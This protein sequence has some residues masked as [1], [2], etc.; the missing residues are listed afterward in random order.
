ML[1]TALSLTLAATAGFAT[2]AENAALAGYGAKITVTC[3]HSKPLNDRWAKAGDLLKAK[4]PA[5]PIIN[6]LKSARINLTFPMALSLKEVGVAMMGKKDGWSRAAA[7]DV[8]V[9]GTVIATITPDVEADGLQ[10]FPVPVTRTNALTL[11]VTKVGPDD[12]KQVYGGFSQVQ[13]I[14]EEDL[15]ALFAPPEMADRAPYVMPTANLGLRPEIKVHGQPRKAEGFPCTIWDKQ[16]IAELKQQIATVP[17]AKDAYERCL[18]F[19]EQAIAEPI[20]VPEKPDD[21]IDKAAA[22]GHTRAVGAIANLGIGYAL[23]GDERFAKDA[24]RMLLRY[25]DLYEGWEVHGSPNFR[26]D[27]SKWSWQRLGDAIWLIQAAWGY[28]LIKASPS[29]TDADRE[30]IDQHFII[31]C[32]KQIVSSA[33]IIAAPTNWSVICCAAVMIGGRVA[34][35]DKLYRMAYE[36]LPQ[37]GG[38][39]IP[40]ISGLDEPSGRNGGIFFHLDKGIDDDGLWAEGAIGYQFMAIRG[41]VVMAEILWRDG[42]D[43]YGYR[44]GRMKLVFDSPIWYHYPGGTESPAIHDSGSTSL[45]GRDAHLYQYA[46][47]R[48]GDATYQ[49][50]LSKVAPS[51][52]SVYNLFLPAFDFTAVQATGLPAV[53]TT[54]FAGVGFAITRTGEG[55]DAKYLLMDYG[56]NRSHGHPDKLSHCFYA[57]GQELYADG[58]S[59]WY[60]TD[61]YRQYYSTTLAHNTVIA[62][63]DSQIMTGGDLQGFC[64]A[65]DLALIRGTC[66]SAIP[67]TGLDRTLVLMGNRLYDVYDVATKAAPYTFD[68]PF[69]SHGKMTVDGALAGSLS[70]WTHADATNPTYKWISDAQAVACDTDWSCTWTLKNGLMRLHGIAEPGTELIVGTTPKGGA[71]LGTVIVRRTTKATA[72][73]TVSDVI[74]AGAEASVAKVERLSGEDGHGLAVDL[75]DGSREVVLVNRGTGTMS[76]AG[77][78]SDAGVVALRLRDGAVSEAIIGGGTTV[79]G[80]GVDLALSE[81]A[82]VSLVRSDDALWQATNH[83]EA[84]ISLTWKAIPVGQASTVAADGSWTATA[85]IADGVIPLPGLTRV[86]LHQPGSST[87]AAVEDARRK[88]KQEAAWAAEQARLAQIATEAAERRKLAAAEAVADDVV[89]LIQAED[90]SAQGGGE[91]SITDKKAAAF[92]TSL[93]M[94]NNHGHWLEWKVQVPQTGWYQVALKYCLEGD[95]NTRYLTI[96]GKPLHEDLRGLVLPGTGGWSNGS[97][98]WKLV[99]ATLPGAEDPFIFRLEAGEHTLRLDSPGGGLNLDYLALLPAQATATRSGIER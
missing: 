37:R 87:V 38:K 67:A 12:A 24:A 8:I 17:A 60:S 65:G 79:T 1:R 41:L 85:A 43:V 49:A 53:P 14:V 23:S 97:D 13:A 52:A 88:A 36:G 94:W 81:P 69:H 64:Q 96:D 76:V 33:S 82:L 72:Y 51:L 80:P 93:T 75:A 62:N 30:K 54:L 4:N 42:I 16:D 7:I 28:D 40:P 59:A 95:E 3:D 58:G 56:P 32:A 22:A 11:V 68:L 55:G 46:L 77:W 20:A 73:A 98:Q 86:D 31:P 66:G 90:F 9:D 74:P 35:D 92:G 71:K 21:D 70:P 15:A 10:V 78:T 89:V 48:Y 50:V 39:P 5:G 6:E 61:I 84:A 45:F 63:A 34:G 2:A 83:G 57:L 18:A 91:I 29:L 27:K 99:S 19:C 47:R 26:H 25:A 44:N